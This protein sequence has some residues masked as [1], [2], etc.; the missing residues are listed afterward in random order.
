[1]N[2]RREL[3]VLEVEIDQARL[4]QEVKSEQAHLRAE[5]LKVLQ[6]VVRALMMGETI[7]QTLENI[8]KKINELDI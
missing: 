2:N 6:D 4:H 7:E 1:M 3:E 5:R 8:R